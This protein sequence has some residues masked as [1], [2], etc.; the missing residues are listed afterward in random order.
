MRALFARLNRATPTADTTDSCATDCADASIP[1]LTPEDESGRSTPPISMSFLLSPLRQLAGALVGND[2]A[3]ELAAGVTI[4]MMLGLVPK[5]NL[6]AVILGMLLL[7]LRVN[8]AAGLLSALL[9]TAVGSMLDGF[10]H[11]L[12]RDVLETPWLQ[13]TFAAL[14]NLPLGPWLNFNNTVVMG[15]LV[16]AIYFSY[17]CYLLSLFAFEAWQ[18]RVAV[19]LRRYRV[20]RIL[21]G[22]QLTANWQEA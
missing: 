10:T 16:L 14:Y 20:T 15:S 6:I 21:L 2:S 7:A 5:G 13:S 19:F 1:H 8:R 17:P 22:L 9:F 3:R 18:P 11:Q 12:G 4:G